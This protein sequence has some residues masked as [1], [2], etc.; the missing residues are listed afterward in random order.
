MCSE[1]NLYIPMSFSMLVFFR[2]IFNEFYETFFAFVIFVG[3]FLFI[4]YI[5]HSIEH[6]YDHF[7]LRVMFLQL[8]MLGFTVGS[9]G[10]DVP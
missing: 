7:M 9:V 8:E 2:L 4:L 5:S 1:K 6:V 3:Q 10:F